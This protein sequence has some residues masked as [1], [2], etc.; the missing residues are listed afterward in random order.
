MLPPS[1]PSRIPATLACCAHLLHSQRRLSAM[2][3]PLPQKQ[4]KQRQER[5]KQRRERLRGSSSMPPLPPKPTPTVSIMSLWSGSQPTSRILRRHSLFQGLLV[6][7]RTETSPGHVDPG[8]FKHLSVSR[9]MMGLKC[10][11]ATRL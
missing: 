6:G 10:F 2:S 5:P 11:G 7:G 1:P 8:S 9:L 3:K 4:L